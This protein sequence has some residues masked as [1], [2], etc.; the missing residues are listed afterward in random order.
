MRD[1]RLLRH[2]RVLDLRDGV[3]RREVEWESPA[4]SAQPPGRRPQRREDLIR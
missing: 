4:G 1:G 2:E 3:L